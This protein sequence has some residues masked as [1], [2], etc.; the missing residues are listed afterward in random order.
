MRTFKSVI[1]MELDEGWALEFDDYLNDYFLNH[2]ICN[3]SYVAAADTYRCLSC[4]AI[5]PEYVI[6]YLRLC[7]STLHVQHT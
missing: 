3:E 6:G 5:V 4:M 7:R 2:L 1:V